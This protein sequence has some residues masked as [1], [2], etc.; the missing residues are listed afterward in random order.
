[1]EVEKA[2]E[3]V[4]KGNGAGTGVKAGKEVKQKK[5]LKPVACSV[6][7]N[8]PTQVPTHVHRKVPT[9]DPKKRN[10][11][12]FFKRESRVRKKGKK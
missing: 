8:V 10:D 2:G 7:R 3:D 4:N 1:M 9:H 12:M 6:F 11:P 5:K